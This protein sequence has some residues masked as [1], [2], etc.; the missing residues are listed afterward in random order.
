MS[1]IKKRLNQILD[2]LKSKEGTPNVPT[3]IKDIDGKYKYSDNNQDYIFNNEQEIKE[4]F[5]KQSKIT[6]VRS[7][8]I[9]IQ[10]VDNSRLERA[11]YEWY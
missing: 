7:N 5:D 11:M 6:G 3:I 4:H 8:Y 2:A 9:V 1:D 10:V